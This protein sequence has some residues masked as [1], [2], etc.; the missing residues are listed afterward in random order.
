MN[1]DTDTGV[2]TG[3]VMNTDFVVGVSDQATNSLNLIFNKNIGH[4]YLKSKKG[5]T[6][7]FIERLP[8]FGLSSIANIIASIKLAKYMKLGFM[9]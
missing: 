8:E 3:N 1:T 2:N 4:N 5:L 6:A 7:M 9:N